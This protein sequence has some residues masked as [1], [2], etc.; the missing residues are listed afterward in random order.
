MGN[1]FLG[2][3]F[4]LFGSNGQLRWNNEAGVRINFR[5]SGILTIINNTHQIA[6][7]D[8]CMNYP[9]VDKYKYFGVCLNDKFN[10]EAH[11]KSYKRKFNYLISRFKMISKRSIPAKYSIN[12]II[13][14]IYNTIL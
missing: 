10:P 8:N 12:L 13:R 5:K 11:L 3:Y 6:I 1:S 14:Q 2:I 7:G 9:I 4:F